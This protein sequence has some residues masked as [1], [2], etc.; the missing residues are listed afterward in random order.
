MPY[1]LLI[2]STTHWFLA[3]TLSYAT[4]ITASFRTFPSPPKK[5]CTEPFSS[6]LPFHILLPRPRESLVCFLSLATICNCTF[7]WFLSF[8]FFLS[9]NQTVDSLW[10]GINLFCPP[11]QVHNSHLLKIIEKRVAPSPP[12]VITF[13]H[14]LMSSLWIKFLF[15]PIE[16]ILLAP[17]LDY[18]ISSV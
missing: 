14:F 7:S 15:P 13:C 2:Q 1:S 12:R 10:V 8:F 4:T 3:Y 11:L 18:F 5:P 16:F 9:L 17:L 6:H